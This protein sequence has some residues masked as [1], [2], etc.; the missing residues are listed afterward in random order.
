M[1][2]VK[3]VSSYPTH[4]APYSCG[5]RLSKEALPHSSY[6]TVQ[7]VSRNLYDSVKVFQLKQLP[8]GVHRCTQVKVEPESGRGKVIYSAEW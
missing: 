5:M 8:T 2:L 6:H 3:N 7:V 1:Q 4:A